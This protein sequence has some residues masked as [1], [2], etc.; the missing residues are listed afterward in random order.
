[1][2]EHGNRPICSTE[3]EKIWYILLDFWKQKHCRTRKLCILRYGVR[4][5][6]IVTLFRGLNNV[7]VPKSGHEI[8]NFTNFVHCWHFGL[9]HWKTT[10]LV[11]EKAGT[12]S[13][14]EIGYFE[15]IGTEIGNHTPLEPSLIRPWFYLNSVRYKDVLSILIYPYR[16]HF[17][18]HYRIFQKFC[19]NNAFWNKENIGHLL[20]NVF[21]KE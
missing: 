11:K 6:C 12:K 1:M 10:T 14:T 5:S 7:L 21:I 19:I 16:W 17:F 20:E 13:E 8:S 15:K 2:A 4:Q 3:F 9:L 18:W